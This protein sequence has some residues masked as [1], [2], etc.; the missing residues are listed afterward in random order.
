MKIL[1]IYEYFDQIGCLTFT[2]VGNGYAYPRIAHFNGCDEGG[3]YFRTMITKP[4]YRQ[5]KDNPVISVCGMSASIRVTHDKD[6]LPSFEPGYFI[7]ALGDVRGV[8]PEVIKEK[9]K[10]NP[11]FRVTVHDLVAY[12]AMTN[13]CINQGRG[14]IFDYDFEMSSRDHKL[15]RTLFSF[16]DMK[17]TTMAGCKITDKC[18]ACGTCMEE[19]TFKAIREG[20]PHY[21]II[22]ERCDACGSCYMVCPEEAIEPAG[23]L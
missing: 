12:P 9:A 14:E 2:T 21:S 7:R 1:E 19:C 23:S 5:L 18:T 16:G 8:P 13:F 10:Q 20:D 17:P 6:D 22:P 11:D 4:F 15:L 3:F